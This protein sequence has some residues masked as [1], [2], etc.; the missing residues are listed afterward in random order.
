MGAVMGR[1]LASDVRLYRRK[2][3]VL[4]KLFH[5]VALSRTTH[6]ALSRTHIVAVSRTRTSPVPD[7][8]FVTGRLAGVRTRNRRAALVRRGGAPPAAGR[9]PSVLRTG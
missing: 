4:M 5:I 8:H 3:G 1:P 7:P 6:V 9:T 2:A